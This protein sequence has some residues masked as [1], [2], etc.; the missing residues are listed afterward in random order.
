[1]IS[2][3]SGY[4]DDDWR[5]RS[6]R[7]SQSSRNI[8]AIQE[9]KD[10]LSRWIEHFE[11]K[12]SPRKASGA[13]AEIWAVAQIFFAVSLACAVGVL[14]LLSGNLADVFRY[15]SLLWAFCLFSSIAAFGKARTLSAYVANLAAW[16]VL[17]FSVSEV[18]EASW[19]TGSASLWVAGILLSGLSALERFCAVHVYFTP[20]VSEQLS[21][22]QAEREKVV[23]ELRKVNLTL[24]LN[25][26]RVGW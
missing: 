1:M 26:R 2:R 18:F 17:C 25:E 4:A 24:A 20:S 5:P 8:D 15:C 3:I 11:H 7:S 6:E 14:F 22:E 16:L 12:T 21:A 19:L 23:A 9:Y 13:T 10:E